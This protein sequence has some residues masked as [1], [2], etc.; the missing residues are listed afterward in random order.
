MKNFIAIIVAVTIVFTL[1]ACGKTTEDASSN[2]SKSP[3]S[4]QEIIDV[5]EY[6]SK[7]EIKGC[8]FALGTSPDTIKEAY[9][10]GDD[11]YWGIGDTVSEQYNIDASPL[12]IREKED[13][14]VRLSASDA[15]FY[16]YKDNEDK[17]IS[18]I[19]QLHDAYS[20]KVGISDTDSIK[21]AISQAPSFDGFAESSDLFFFYDNP[22]D[23]YALKYNFGDNELS[24]YFINGKL[25]ATCIKN[26]KL[27]N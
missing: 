23:V 27:W 25:S 3:V 22:D 2:V 20:F 1:T 9:H 12:D 18:F 21:N 5:A 16:Y 14:E 13:G 19:A 17:G 10:Y 6:A 24:F 8:E 11:E 26:T 7:G 4:S 15:K